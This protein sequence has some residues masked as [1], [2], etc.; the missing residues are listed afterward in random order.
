MKYFLTLLFSLK[1]PCLYKNRADKLTEQECYDFFTKQFD[2]VVDVAEN[3]VEVV[4]EQNAQNDE[5]HT[6]DRQ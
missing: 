5:N 4:N 3:S 6:Q 2:D 1:Q